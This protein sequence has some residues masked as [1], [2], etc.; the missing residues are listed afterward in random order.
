TSTSLGGSSTTGGPALATAEFDHVSTQGNW[1]RTRWSGKAIMRQAD[2]ALPAS[3]QGFRQTGHQLTVSGSGDIAP[4]TGSDAGSGV[5]N[6]L[7]GVFAGLIAM[8]VIGV[9]FM[10]AEYRRGLIRTTFAACPRRGRVLA[11][12]AV[13]LGSVTLVAGLVAVAIAIPLGQHL[14]SGN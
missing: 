10:T 9:M 2:E 4:A 3:M 6:I 12:K 8:I 14:L 7:G 1:P 5:Q 13:V 11:A